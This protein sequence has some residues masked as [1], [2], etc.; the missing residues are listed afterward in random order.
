MNRLNRYANLKTAERHA[1]TEARAKGW[2]EIVAIDY[3]CEHGATRV[4]NKHTQP[5]T[6]VIVGEMQKLFGITKCGNQYYYWLEA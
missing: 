1:N 5:D 2:L 6:L 4:E 3:L